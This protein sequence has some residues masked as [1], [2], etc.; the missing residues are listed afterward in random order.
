[1][2]PVSNDGSQANSLGLSEGLPMPT[3]PREVVRRL[4]EEVLFREAD[5]AG[6]EHYTT[7]LGHGK[8]SALGLEETLR[9]SHEYRLIIG[10]LV[11]EIEFVYTTFLLRAP[12]REE[13]SQSINDFRNVLG[14]FAES[15]DVIHRGEARRYLGIRP[16]NLEMDITNQCN[17]RCIMCYFSDERIYRRKREDISIEDFAAIASQVFPLCHK[18][19]LSIATEPLIHRR[20]GELLAI[21]AKYRI[22]RVYMN[23][24]GLLLSETIIHQMIESQFHAVAVSIDAATKETYERI[25]VGS[26]FDNVIANIQAVNRAKARLNSDVPH[27]TF[28]FVLMKSNIEELPALVRLAHGLKVEG[29]AAVHMVPYTNT[30]THEES[31]ERHKDLCNHMLDATRETAKQY[32]VHVALPNNF[33]TGPRRPLPF[34]VT[35]T[36]F[37]LNTGVDKGPRS[38][39]QFPWHF[40]GIDCYGNVVPCGWWYNEAPMGNIKSERFE[41]IWN[42]QRY[43]TLRFQH[44]S[45]L[46]RKTCATCPA[47]GVGGVNDR[48]AFSAKSPFAAP[49]A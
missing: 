28:N 43:Q 48:Q 8:L 35:P 19:S 14:T 9:A 15:R 10:P 16:L 23:T 27:L 33:E 26:H 34:A 18:M 44:M 11:D 38:C 24:N 22:P 21:A 47:A 42:N 6:L 4:Y 20:F 41:D 13:V 3:A 7:Q 36:Y 49:S 30:N 1:M 17:L 40:V 31:L 2:S 37:D 45:G 29:I 39:C 25:R 32:N 5:A 12:T 46:L